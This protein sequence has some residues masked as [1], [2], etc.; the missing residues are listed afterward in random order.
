MKRW[1]LYVAA[2]VA[3]TVAGAV[4]LGVGGRLA[5]A[6]LAIAG[7]DGPRFSW[8]GSLEVLLVGT[9]YGAIGGVLLAAS[10]RIWPRVGRWR[11]AGLGA[12]L[13]G[14]AWATSTVGR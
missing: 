12:A 13:L 5:M 2:I 4:V 9:F 8:G 3:G 1:R 7:G 14:I 11:G 6:A 10:Q